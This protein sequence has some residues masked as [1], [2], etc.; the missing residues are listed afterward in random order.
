MQRKNTAMKRF[1]KQNKSIPHLAISL[2]F[3]FVSA[4]ASSQLC[5]DSV[6]VSYS[7][8][9][10][11]PGATVAFLATAPPGATNPHFQWVYNGAF[12]SYD[13]STYV[14]NSLNTGDIVKCIFTGISCH[15]SAITSADSIVVLLS[16]V[17]KPSI[18]ISTDASYICKGSSVTFFATAMN[19][20]DHPDYQWK[21]NGSN[22][23]ANSDTFATSS[24]N[25]GDIV[26]CVLTVDPAFPCSMPKTASSYGVA[27]TVVD[28]I[29]PSVSITASANDICPGTPVTFVAAAQNASSS[30]SYQWKLNE[31]KAGTDSSNFTSSNLNN[32]DE[33]YCMLTDSNGCS[34]NP[35]SSEKI[36]MSVK[37]LPEIVMNPVDTFVA[38]GTQL[39]ISASIT[40]NISS[41]QWLPSQSLTNNSSLTPT[42]QPLSSNTNYFFNA[43]TTDG[44]AVSKEIT[45]KILTDLVMPNAFSP[46]GDGHNEVFRIPPNTYINLNE[47]SIFN[48]WGN[49][50]FSTTNSGKGWD[51]TV[52]GKKQDA[53][54]YIYIISGTDKNGKVLYKG[55]F[56]LVR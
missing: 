22:T 3:C 19:A 10:I 53:G 26:N 49:K 13:I 24:L 52:N 31:A 51:G 37:S 15:G 2:L 32:G 46:N 20:G 28:A 29:P 38:Q 14:A 47:F 48:R 55:S 7:P 5:G 8:S 30:V 11:C 44:C 42:T 17:S 18:S 56:I 41:Y 25:N 43:I 1:F 33:V 6:K 39:M 40:G 50:I 9:M 21:I 35:A 4:S 23:G 27:M 54:M 36:M 12:V 34:R 16:P 45:I